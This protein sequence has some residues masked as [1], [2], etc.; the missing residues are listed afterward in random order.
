VPGAPE[1]FVVGDAAAVVDRGKPVPGV[2][3]GAIQGGRR[4]AQNLV[5]TLEG[6]PA[7]PFEYWNKGDLATIGGTARWR[8]SA[9]SSSSAAPWRG[10]SGCSSTSSTWPASATA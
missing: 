10:C 5:A 9:G 3:Q 7:P 2:A 4:A 1:V 8:T 6:R